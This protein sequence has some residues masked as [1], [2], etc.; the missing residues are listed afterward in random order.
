M[1][2]YSSRRCW[3]RRCRHYGPSGDTTKKTKRE[4]LRVNWKE[5]FSFRPINYKKPTFRLFVLYHA[6][7]GLSWLVEIKLPSLNIKGTNLF[8]LALTTKGRKTTNFIQRE[9]RN[10]PYLLWFMGARYHRIIK[11]HAVWRWFP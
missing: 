5:R 2:N 11:N 10:E 3:N 7:I 6:F 4:K 1:T 9:K 8:S